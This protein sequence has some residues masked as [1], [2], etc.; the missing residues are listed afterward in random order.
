M[1]LANIILGRNEVIVIKSGSTT[2]MIGVDVALNFGTVQKVN[3]LTDRT[4]VGQSVLFNPDQAIPFMILSGITFYK[5]N[6]DL[7]TLTEPP[8]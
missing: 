1:G 7:I 5:V 6:E 8:A 2:G 4:R 3:Q